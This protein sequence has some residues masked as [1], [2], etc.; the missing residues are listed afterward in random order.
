[1]VSFASYNELQKFVN[2]LKTVAE[3]ALEESLAESLA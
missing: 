3:E 2:E 1:M